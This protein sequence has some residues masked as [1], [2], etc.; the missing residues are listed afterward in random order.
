MGG[1]STNRSCTVAGARRPKP[2]FDA[3]LATGS[4]P[5]AWWSTRARS[6]RWVSSVIIEVALARPKNRT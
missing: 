6:R 2:R 3:T 1:Q 4:R 5:K